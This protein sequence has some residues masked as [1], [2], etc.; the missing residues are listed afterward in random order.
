MLYNVSSPNDH[1]IPYNPLEE[2]SNTIEVYYH[3][4]QAT[5]EEPL[6]TIEAYCHS[7]QAAMIPYH[8]QNLKP[9]AC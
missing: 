6:N 9:I 8:I 7:L 1:K 4:F 3:A 2:P 5:N